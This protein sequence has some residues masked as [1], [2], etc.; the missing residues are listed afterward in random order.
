MCFNP[1][2]AYFEYELSQTKNQHKP[3][4]NKHLIFTK[5]TEGEINTLNENAIII[6]CGKCLACRTHRPSK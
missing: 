6:P 1:K 3:T 4:I 5:R 2:F